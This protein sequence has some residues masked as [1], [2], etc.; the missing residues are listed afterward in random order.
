MIRS[1]GYKCRLQMKFEYL[2]TVSPQIAGLNTLNVQIS[3]PKLCH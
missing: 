3:T 1:K 2:K